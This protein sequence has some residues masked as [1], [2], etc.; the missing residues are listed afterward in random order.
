MKNLF[1]AR[2]RGKKEKKKTVLLLVLDRCNCSHSAWLMLIMGQWEIPVRATAQ[3][4]FATTLAG[5]GGSVAGQQ[6][7]CSMLT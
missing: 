6:M 2:G 3:D 1:L 7:G 5:A 4:G